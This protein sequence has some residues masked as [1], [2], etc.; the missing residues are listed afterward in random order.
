M[1]L[2]FLVCFVRVYVCCLYE[3]QSFNSD[4]TVLELIMYTSPALNSQRSAGIRDMPPWPAFKHLFNG[5]E[6][7]IRE[8]ENL[9]AVFSTASLLCTML[10]GYL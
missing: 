6:V 8:E 1:T 4:L 2:T 3:T 7:H 5:N 10:K 9:C